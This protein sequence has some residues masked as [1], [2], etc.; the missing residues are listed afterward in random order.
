MTD[1]QDQELS[2]QILRALEIDHQYSQGVEDWN[3]DL[4]NQIRRCGRAAG[5][6]LGYRVRTFVTGTATPGR[7]RV[8]VVVITSNPADEARIRERGD[9]LIRQTLSRLLH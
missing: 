5:R 8:W 6:Q 9:L 7:L 3:Q 1:D 4:V 2:A